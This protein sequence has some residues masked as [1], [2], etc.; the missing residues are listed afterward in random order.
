VKSKFFYSKI[1][2]KVFGW[3]VLLVLQQEKV[4][5]IVCFSLWMQSLKV[6]SLPVFDSI[7]SY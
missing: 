7:V 2:Y 4:M 5:A 1:L 3:V 6:G